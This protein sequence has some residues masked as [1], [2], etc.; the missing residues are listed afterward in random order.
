MLK[1]DL[2]H[3]PSDKVIE[4]LSNAENLCFSSD[5]NIYLYDI[6]FTQDFSGLSNKEEVISW[7]LINR[8]FRMQVII[9]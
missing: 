4:I 2:D 1:V 3:F 6:D 8:D 7:P 5:K 9:I